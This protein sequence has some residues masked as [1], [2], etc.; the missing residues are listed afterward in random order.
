MRAQNV[1]GTPAPLHLGRND[2]LSPGHDAV[3]GLEG[4]KTYLVAK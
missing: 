1:D 4:V 2:N 3:R